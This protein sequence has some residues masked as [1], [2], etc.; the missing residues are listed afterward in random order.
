M[1][2]GPGPTPGQGSRKFGARAGISW[3]W[4]EARTLRRVGSWQQ[5]LGP[6]IRG[7]GQSTRCRARRHVSFPPTPH[8]GC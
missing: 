8:G 5:T 1:G 4:F 6:G 2:T 3:H 7:P